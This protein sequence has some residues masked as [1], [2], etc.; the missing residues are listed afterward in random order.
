MP[1]ALFLCNWFDVKSTGVESNNR[2]FLKRYRAIWNLRE[3]FATFQAA[4]D[5]LITKPLPVLGVIEP[6]K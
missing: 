5:V 3:L 1:R 4:W 2:Y 6:I